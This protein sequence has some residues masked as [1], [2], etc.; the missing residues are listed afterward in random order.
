MTK[1]NV[2][3]IGCGLIGTKRAEALSSIGNIVGCSDIDKNKSKIFS[4]RFNTKIYDNWEVLLKQDNIKIVIIATT[5]DMLCEITKKAIKYKKNILV[6]KPAS[7]NAKE[8]KELI[9]AAKLSNSKIHVG[10]NHRFHRSFIKAKNLIDNNQIG[11]LMFIRARY[12]HGGRLGYEKEWRA[13]PEISGGGE[14]LDQGSHLID[15]SNWFLGNLSFSSGYMKNYY[16]DMAVEDNC[17]MILKNK[18]EKIAFLHVSCT[19]WKNTFSFEIYGKLGKIDIS[20]LGGSY[21]T[22]KITLFKLLPEMGPPETFSWEFPMKDNSWTTELIEFFNDI[23]SNTNKL[24][25]LDDALFNLEIIDK[26]Y[27]NSGYDNFAKSS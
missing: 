17:F 3:I 14:L 26:I 16:W 5:H 12:G 25:N 7:R 4:E 1:E 23:K 21:G 18:K 6:E 19:E 15:L 9:D 2:G 11:E 10:F 27:K 22:E 8:L 20:G 13:K 24:N